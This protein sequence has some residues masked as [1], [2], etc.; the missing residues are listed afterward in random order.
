MRGTE[1]IIRTMKI[2]SMV[3]ADYFMDHVHQIGIRLPF[4]L[5]LSFFALLTVADLTMILSGLRMS[6]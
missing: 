1:E 5:I 4:C 6:P 3:R 2:S